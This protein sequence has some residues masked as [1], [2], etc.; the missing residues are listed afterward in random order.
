MLSV[1]VRNVTTELE[2]MSS[3]A[4]PVSGALRLSHDISREDVSRTSD[5]TLT[6]EHTFAD[7]HLS[8]A[9]LRGLSAA[10]FTRPSPVQWK[11]IPPARLGLD[12]VVQAKAGTGKTLVYV[13]AA[14]HALDADRDDGKIQVLVLAP[15]REIA[16]Q[17]SRALIDVSKPAEPKLRAATFIGGLSLAEDESKLKGKKRCPHVAIGTP[18]RIRQLVDEGKM[19][20]SAVKLFV[21]DEADKLMDPSF[22]DDVTA[23]YNLMPEGKQFIALSATYPDALAAMLER[24]MR[25]P[26][27]VRLNREDGVLEGAAQFAV[28]VKSHPLP[29]AQMA[30][31]TTALL[32][33]L[34]S[35]AF[36]QCLVFSNYTTRAESMCARA[37]ASGWPAEFIAASQ[38]QVFK[39]VRAM[40]VLHFHIFIKI[41]CFVSIL[42]STRSTA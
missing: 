31:K 30:L 11:A 14:L 19:D 39:L 18:G 10:G 32:E 20:V 26:A 37:V 29:Q 6:A 21:L 7:L 5:V 9:I 40:Y 13:V 4:V 12:L 42:V 1:V 38:D 16:V 22:V 34:D 15:T 35:V 28:V 25:R 23:V 8:D 3:A 17:G 2:R 33:L 41:H 24:Y 36:S 27:H